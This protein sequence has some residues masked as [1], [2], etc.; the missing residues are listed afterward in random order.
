MQPSRTIEFGRPEW[1][2]HLGGSFH[3]PE[4]G[5]GISQNWAGEK[6]CWCVLPGLQLDRDYSARLEAAPVAP[7]GAELQEV[8]LVAPGEKV[9]FHA[10]FPVASDS[11]AVPL[12][13]IPAHT[14]PAEFRWRRLPRPELS[15]LM[16]G[17]PLATLAYQPRP[18]LQIH[19]FLMRRELLTENNILTF[20]PNFALTPSSYGNR[21]DSR[22]VSFRFFRLMLYSLS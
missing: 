8:R 9:V 19:E 10:V 22:T 15:V 11:F 16:N 13:G 5:G 12:R 20:Q 2:T 4:E 6:S 14:G 18:D 17:Q 21:A 7:Y 3:G 1:Q